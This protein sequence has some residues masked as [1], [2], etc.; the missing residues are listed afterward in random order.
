MAGPLRRRRAEGKDR[1]ALLA[2][3]AER[4]LITR[5]RSEFSRFTALFE[6]QNSGMKAA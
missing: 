4:S 2:V 3:D 1:A 6:G 5:P